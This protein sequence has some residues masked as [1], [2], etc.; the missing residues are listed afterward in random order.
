ME[1]I[2]EKDDKA[3]E[4]M[5]ELGKVLGGKVVVICFDGTDIVMSY[6]VPNREIAQRFIIDFGK[7]L[8]S[9]NESKI[10]NSPFTA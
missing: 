2:E 6:T 3:Q 8:E 4:L 5:L 9:H 7:L 10:K 1:M